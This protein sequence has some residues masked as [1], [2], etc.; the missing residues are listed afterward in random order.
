VHQ[1]RGNAAQSKGFAAVAW[2]LLI[3]AGAGSAAEINP[4]QLPPPA[5]MTVD[6]QRDVEPIFKAICYR[7]HG[8]ERPKSRFRL[9]NRASALKGGNNGIDII[10]GDSAKSPLIH[11]VSRLV[12]D[13]EMPPEGK[14]E[15][16]TAEQVG[17]LRTWIDQGAS[18]GVAAATEQ[19]AASFSPA[20]GWFYVS[21]DKTKFRELEGAKDRE[22]G[23]VE[24]FSVKEQ[25]GPDK[26]F[27]ME[28]RVVFPEPD[29]KLK[30]SLDQADV[31]FVRGG[32]EEWRKYYDDRGG[33]Y[34][35]STPPA[36]D[37]NRDLHVDNGRAWIDVGLTLPRW[38]LMTV[39]YEYQFKEGTK[40]TL[41]W[42][43]V[44]G[45]NIYPAS[46]TIQEHTQIIK[47]DISHDLYSWH[48]EDNARLELYDSHTQHDDAAGFTLGPTPDSFTHT[49][50]GF[51]HT[52]GMNTLRLERQIKP[53]WFVS[54][55]YL[56]SRFDGDSSM[57]Q[58]TTDAIGTP[59]AGNFWSTDPIELQREAH[60]CSFASLFT[61]ISGLSVSLGT[62]AE[63][64]H[65]EGWGNIHLDSG[66]PN[67]PSL[68]ILQPAMVQ[69]DLDTTRT[70]ENLGV[71]WSGLPFTV[72]FGEARLEQE[73]ISQFEE[74][75]GDVSSAFLRDT[76]ASNDRYDARLGF[77][78]SPWRWVSW[79]G[80]YRVRESDTDYNQAR[81]FVLEGDGYS[82]FIRRR[83]IS[84]DEAETKLSL[85]PYKWLKTS[86]S[87]QHVTTDYSTTTDPVSGNISPGGILTAGRYE[88]DVY[89]LGFTFVPNGRLS[90]SSTFTYS[91]SHASTA[92]NG[93]PSVAP[94]RGEV[95]SL[96]ET[97]N[98]SL[99]PATDLRASYG[100]SQAD[101]GQNNAADGLPLGLNF[102]RHS[103]SAG[104]T[105]R[106]TSRLSTDLR[107]SF[108]KYSENGTGGIN[109]YTAHGIFASL[110]FKLP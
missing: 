43:T 99:N 71:R 39:G 70:R 21:G 27:S 59:V 23:G 53:W 55:G 101:Y 87:Y 36:Y 89:G 15:P 13:M 29:I 8:P 76:D 65:Q 109:D 90:L 32:F 80:H 12:K 34:A 31:G 11:Y 68:F 6:F 67:V 74:E 75:A 30:L 83:E 81:R 102:V 47:F 50:Y 56:Y 9:D 28:G 60:M 51:T 72:L 110:S 95:Y 2:L 105:R 85:R 48:V 46:E 54:A 62:Q 97:V 10:S 42:G 63:F 35:P 25:I 61:P 64:Q 44:N 14:G 98:Y 52:Q 86:L 5:K 66:D 106:W 18:W 24:E 108:Y 16:L 93:D 84:G 88:A 38:P 91:D 41:E 69:S 33:Y 40:S 45:K 104:I 7:C 17:I 77:N 92:Q 26:K 1:K 73:R 78:T 57:H 3:C 19:F 103:L 37:L 20:F 96:I 79:T 58:T 82:A 94:Y 100:Y 22:N 4:A 49:K 107:Y